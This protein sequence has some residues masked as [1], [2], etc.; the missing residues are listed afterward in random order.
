MRERIIVCNGIFERESSIDLKAI[1]VVF[2]RP[3]CV[4]NG[5]KE[6]WGL[7]WYGIPTV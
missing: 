1:G 7:S 2:T 4:R 5:G 6:G 3:L